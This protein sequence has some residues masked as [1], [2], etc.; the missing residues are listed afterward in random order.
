MP[1]KR[2]KDKP[3][4]LLRVEGRVERSILCGKGTFRSGAKEEA[5]IIP[6]SDKI[7]QTVAHPGKRKFLKITSKAM[8]KWVKKKIV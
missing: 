3:P 8:S 6:H 4:E 2:E 7:V 5:C 1:P